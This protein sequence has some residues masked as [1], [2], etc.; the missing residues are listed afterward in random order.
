MKS[1]KS[2]AASLTPEQIVEVEE[3]LKEARA[4]IP[5]CLHNLVWES[6]EL[7]YVDDS[8]NRIDKPVDR[9]AVAEAMVEIFPETPLKVIVIDLDRKDL[10]KKEE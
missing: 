10:L 2:Y 4:G 7:Y 1:Y 6:G 3:L 5:E 9:A 8:G